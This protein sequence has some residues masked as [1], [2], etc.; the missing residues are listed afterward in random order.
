MPK[1]HSEALTDA[2]ST[3]H[4]DISGDEPFMPSATAHGATN[5]TQVHT[6]TPSQT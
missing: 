2:L 6:K 5:G 3:A 4:S 1:T